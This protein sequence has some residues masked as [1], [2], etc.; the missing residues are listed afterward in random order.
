MKASK[1]ALKL[2]KRIKEDFDIDVIPEIHRNY[3]GYWQRKEG[4][5]SWFMQIKPDGLWTVGSQYTATEIA[6]AKKLDG[7]DWTGQGDFQI[8]IESK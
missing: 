7:S 3:P 1:L 6:K 5:S 8:Y 4:V 2:Q